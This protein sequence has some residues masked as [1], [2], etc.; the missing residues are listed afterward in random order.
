MFMRVRI[1][2]GKTQEDQ[3]SAIRVMKAVFQILDKIPKLKIS[4]AA[5]R[6]AAN[7]RKSV[8]SEKNK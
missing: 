7:A 4:E 5:K 2:I 1:A 8:D 6:K 3:D